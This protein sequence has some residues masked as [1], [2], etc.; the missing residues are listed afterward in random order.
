MKGGMQAALALGVGDVLG[1]R[2]KM[3][4]ATILAAAAATGGLGG[5]AVKR[6]TKVLG[7]TAALGTFAPQLGELADTVRSDL[8]DAGKAAATATVTSRIESLTESLHERAELVR[9]PG[10]AAGEAA[11]DV[12]GGSPLR[13]GKHER[14]PRAQKLDLAL[15]V[16]E[17]SRSEQHP[18][19]VEGE[20]DHA[21]MSCGGGTSA[22][23]VTRCNSAKESPS[24]IS[25]TR[26]PTGVT[27]IT[28][29]SV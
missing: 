18:G 20:G 4:R 8:M 26:S 2:P 19:T 21:H 28:A 3:R 9:D 29:R 12:V 6:A 1:R 17:A 5:L 16:R 27:S 13:R 25:R 22:A 11:F 23:R 24:T 15:E 7:S 10:A 14:S